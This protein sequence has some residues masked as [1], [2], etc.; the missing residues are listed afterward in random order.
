[1]PYNKYI[2]GI[3]RKVDVIV[4]TSGRKTFYEEPIGK[5]IDKWEIRNAIVLMVTKIIQNSLFLLLAIIITKLCMLIWL[6]INN[7]LILG[8]NILSFPH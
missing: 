6:Y 5:E 1:L 2:N 4:I 3:M 8:I 7:Y